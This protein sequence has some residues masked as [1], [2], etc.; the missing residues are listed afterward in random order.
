MWP[1]LNTSPVGLWRQESWLRENVTSF[2]RNADWLTQILEA[3]AV[4]KE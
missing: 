1:D 3:P 2:L 4:F